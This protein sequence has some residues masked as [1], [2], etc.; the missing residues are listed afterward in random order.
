MSHSF[1]PHSIIIPVLL[2]FK[3]HFATD[4][5]YGRLNVNVALNRPAFIS[6]VYNDGTWG[7]FG[8]AYKGVDGNSDPVMQQTDSSCVHTDPESNPWFGVD[9]G[10]AL[11][12]YGVLLTA[13]AEM[14]GRPIR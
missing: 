8:P 4:A 3:E 9:L 13:R 14:W 7:Q 10:A 2:S 1:I 11:Y 6:S 12:V 5:V